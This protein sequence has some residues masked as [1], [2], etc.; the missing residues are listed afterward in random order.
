MLK[1]RDAIRVPEVWPETFHR[2]AADDGL[3]ERPQAARAQTI[4]WH[5]QS[6]RHCHVHRLVVSVQPLRRHPRRPASRQL[7]RL[8]DAKGR[9]A[10][11]NLLDYGC[12][13]IFPESLRRRRGR[14]LSRIAARDEDLVVHA[15]EVWGFKRSTRVIDA[16]N[17]WAR[18]IYG[19]LLDDRV[20]TIADGVNRHNTVARK[21]SR[22]TRR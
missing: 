17:I 9:P 20:R 6:D 16:L 2:P 3:D 5:A 1:D 18:F 22:C 4:R 8:R 10:G 15:Y 19:P 11:I 12:I 7:H 21:L 13:R 14:P